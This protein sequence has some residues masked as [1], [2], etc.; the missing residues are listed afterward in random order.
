MKK[1]GSEQTNNYIKKL[2]LLTVIVI[3]NI[4]LAKSQEI[5]SFK[6][7]DFMQ[8]NNIDSLQ[9]MATQQ[10]K[11]PKQLLHTLFAIELNFHRNYSYFS[12]THFLAIDSLC[13]IVNDKSATAL[14]K[15]LYIKKYSN[16]NKDV[17]F[18]TL[19]EALNV[20]VENSDTASIASCYISL[21]NFNI[22]GVKSL[23]EHKKSIDNYYAKIIDLVSHS[24]NA[25]YKI[26][27]IFAKCIYY[28]DVEIDSNKLLIELHKGLELCNQTEFLKGSKLF[29]YLGLG[30]SYFLANNIKKGN[31]YYNLGLNAFNAKQSLIYAFIMVN[32]GNYWVEKKEYKKAKDIYDELY[33][34]IV[35]RYYED[36]MP[37]L[38]VFFTDMATINYKLS[39]YQ[40]AAQNLFTLDS[41]TKNFDKNSRQKYFLDIQTKYETTTKDIAIEKLK[42]TKNSYLIIVAVSLVLITIFIVLIAFIIRQNKRLIQLNKFKNKVHSIISYELRVPIFDMLGL[43]KK[44]NNLMRKNDVEVLNEVSKKIDVNGNKIVNLLNNVLAWAVIDQVKTNRTTFNLAQSVMQIDSLY[45]ESFAA[46]HISFRYN[47]PTIFE[48]K[49]NKNIVE[50]MLRNWFDVLMNDANTKNIVVDVGKEN[51]ATVINVSSDGCSNG[52][53]ISM[54]QS[55]LR[56]SKDVNFQENASLG[57]SLIAYFSQQKNINV[58]LNYINNQSVFKIY[59]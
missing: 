26:Y 54:M 1:K 52:D 57:L 50:L 51:R 47:L 9:Q 38:R 58:R 11:N 39:Y 55:L 28:N 36:E 33:K 13:K 20:F 14:Y 40:Q 24:T 10:K 4:A 46:Q 31:Y 43:S 56:N 2:V 21:M 34:N 25:A 53:D 45:K 41:L 15:L 29:F 8:S 17:L 30:N 59:V 16:F 12:G 44:A 27:E 35:L 6:H 32:K 19:N 5:A 42:Q 22:V 3:L 37:L 48:I 49:S 7:T 18:K 23:A